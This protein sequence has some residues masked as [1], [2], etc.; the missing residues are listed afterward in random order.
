MKVQEL[1]DQLNEVKDKSKE[2]RM[3]SLV[4]CES[5][6]IVKVIERNDEVKIDI[7]FTGY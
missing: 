6:E 4:D 3:Y 2:I 5:Y 1:I 7:D